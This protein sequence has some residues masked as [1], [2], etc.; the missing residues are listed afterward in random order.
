[1]KHDLVLPTASIFMLQ[2]VKE[3][4]S[5]LPG[6]LY[7]A[8]KLIILDRNKFIKFASCPD[9]G[10]FYNYADAI[11]FDNKTKQNISRTCDNILYPNNPQLKMRNP[12]GAILMVTVSSYDEKKHCFYP[13]KVYV[14]Q[15]LK[16]ALSL[17]LSLPRRCCK[18]H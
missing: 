16:D 6:S 8:S 17:L 12:C 18:Y 10:K 9:C 11:C 4:A 7:K 3:L 14:F 13:K 2:P 15:S 1:M 5:H